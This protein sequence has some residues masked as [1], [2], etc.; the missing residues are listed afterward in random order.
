MPPRRSARV[1]EATEQRACAFP[2]LPQPVELLIFSLVPVDS[3]LRCAEV[4]RGWRAT[5]AQPALWSRVD[6]SAESGVAQPVSAALLHALV[7]RAAGA[8]TVLDVSG[9]D[10][11]VQDLCAALRAAG[12][13]EVLHA[14]VGNRPSV[15]ESLDTMAA[16]LAAAPRLR[17]LF[18]DL[19]CG[20]D[21]ASTF[22]TADSRYALL[23]VQTLTLVF[24]GADVLLPPAVAVA[25]A[26]ARFQPSLTKLGLSGADFG[27]LTALDVV[28]RHRV[29]AP[30]PSR[31]L[32]DEVQADASFHAS[33]GARD[34]LWRAHAACAGGH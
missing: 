34:V 10:I 5:V 3:R 7:A 26:D 30:E 12:T 11:S 4:A 21:E 20:M 6:L 13:V 15:T 28:A 19:S 22:V 1:A 24:I 17:D 2:Q 32:Y 18:C 16:Y 23:R 31:A 29:R 27:E 8:L 33:A 25:L 14:A 9:A